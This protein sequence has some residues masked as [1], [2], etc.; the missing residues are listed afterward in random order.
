MF[1]NA[2]NSKGSIA[3]FSAMEK[4]K[5]EEIEAEVFR[6]RIKNIY[7]TVDS[8]TGE[9][10]ISAPARASVHRLETFLKSQLGWIR[11]QRAGISVMPRR[12]KSNFDCGDKIE[13]LGKEYT[14]VTRA[15]KKPYG[16]Y[17]AFENLEMYA[18]ADA[19]FEYKRNLMDN[20][21]A[22]KLASIIPQIAEKWQ[23]RLG[24]RT[25]SNQLK[26]IFKIVGDKISGCGKDIAEKNITLGKPLKF[27]YKRMKSCWGSCNIWKKTITLNT[28]LAKKNIRI[29][30]YITAH[31]L[32]H[33][34]EIK[35]NKSFNG[36]MKTFFQDWKTIEQELKIIDS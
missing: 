28:E 24:I 13:L 35:H 30:E 10:V 11:K 7:V 32:L 23:E 20:F 12:K 19:K 8:V 26:L 3:R 1:I 22:S 21:Y 29:I 33:L 2:A 14:L 34:K 16:V 17:A 5:V 18:P 27:V 9:A 4:I 36:C 25:E 15:G 6:K 31:E